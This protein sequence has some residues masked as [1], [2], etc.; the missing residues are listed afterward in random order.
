MQISP[1]FKFAILKIMRLSVQQL[2]LICV[3]ISASY[4]YETNAQEILNQEVSIF[5]KDKSIVSVLKELS[6]QTDVKFVYSS[7]LIGSNK[8]VSID[9]KKQKLSAILNN[10]LQPLLIDFQVNGNNIIL[11]RKSV[12]N[13]EKSPNVDEVE[14]EKTEIS[15][16]VTEPLP[17]TSKA[18]Q[19][20]LLGSL[21]GRITDS[22][23]GEA[24]PGASILLKGTN[25]GS[26]TNL[27][28][29]FSMSL[30]P[31]GKQTFIVSYLGYQ[32]QELPF[33]ITDGNNILNIKLKEASGELNEVVVRGSLEGQQKA[34]NQQ[35]TADNI[36]NVI[37]A[38]L[39]G[40]FPDL[41]VAEALQR[42]PGINIERDRGEGG[43]VQMRGAPPS[44][45]TIN[46]NGEQIP[47]TQTDGQRNEELSIIP[48]D[49][50]SSI[51]VT[52]AITSDMDG[53]NIGGT[54]DFRTPS[55]KN[56][57]WKGKAE[58]GG[59]YNN[60]VQ[61]A[62][63]IGKF[64]INRRFAPTDNLPDGRFGINIGG[65]YFG[66][67]LGRDRVS[68]NYNSSY[69]KVN[70]KDY[71]L[72]TYYRLR[73]LENFRSRT[74]IS[75]AMD[76]KFSPKSDIYLNYMYSR[77][78]DFDEEARTQFDFNAA[79]WT[80]DET[81]GLATGNGATTTRRFIN[82]RFNDVNNHSL[83]FGGNH[84]LGKMAVDYLLFGSKSHN[85]AFVGRVYDLRSTAQATT[86]QGWGTDFANVIG[87]TDIHDPFAIRSIRS[88]TDQDQNIDA[89]NLSAKINFTVPY[90]I[91]D[92]SSSIKFGGKYRTLNNR[93][94]IDNKRYNFANDGTVNV[95]SLFARYTSER[96]DNT[97]LQKRVRFGPTLN[98]KGFDSFIASNPSLWKFDQNVSTN[99]SI[100][101][102]YDADE[103][104]F[105]AY[106]MNKIN[107]NKLMLLTGLRYERTTV[108]YISRAFEF[109]GSGN[110]KQQSIR[111]VSG[112][113]NFDFILPNLHLKYSIDEM[114]NIR[115]ALTYS[116]A[117]SNFA[118][119]A[120]V[121][122]V[123]V[124]NL[125]ISLGNPSLKPASSTNLD[126]LFERYFKNVGILS[127]G[128]FMKTIKDFNFDRSF[129]EEREV[130]VRN[131]ATG[132]FEPIRETF[133]INQAQNGETASIFGFELNL[134]SNLTFLPGILKGIGVYANYTYTNSKASTF[135]RKEVRLP[136]Q[137]MH[138]GNF[139]LSFDYK[140]LSV[141]GSFN[142]NGGLIRTL[143]PSGVGEN[144]GDFDTWR[145]DRYQLDLS[146]S[147]AITKK[148]RAYA[149]F[150][151]VTNR[152]DVEYFGNRSR[153]S[154]LEYFDWWNR[155]GISYNF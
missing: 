29:E 121:Q 129:T 42:I 54:V 80:V 72:P 35:R 110:V 25:K 33:E 78:Y 122:S 1:N 76:Y 75:A 142:Y 66:S 105:A 32:K 38:D 14:A 118:D 28:G 22:K 136:G 53:D 7:K 88:Y 24:L 20:L 107:F 55:G 27:R 70:N 100:P 126:F 152:P 137:A 11:N 31:V 45:T 68:Y 34:L 21:N 74:G 140:K 64:S 86:F 89:Q 95:N 63:F 119:L 41:N 106:V 98:Y 81:T 91:G 120:P 116:Y 39:I 131:D 19:T 50:L 57:N 18:K 3:F 143:G 133:T 115:G 117:R 30:V 36:K 56:L 23:T 73:D 71:V 109:D 134:Q 94:E 46:I 99:E 139:A 37:S 40:R 84:T 82:P 58:L 6:T 148:I 79:R 49:Q 44:F 112:G 154:N 111:D 85:D 104:V 141:K 61:R 12:S 87:T 92:N 9:M 146:A 10:L 43:E 130:F 96:E 4:A 52:K 102:F 128:V 51:E 59:G 26:I 145:D 124:N 62:S 153:V 135:D 147:Y 83:T 5:V 93:R 114:T 155:F 132:A 67:N 48:V 101:A 77:R 127:G 2:L 65:S 60:I 103:N 151:N 69:T 150:I 108:N 13:V 47:G 16:S 97:F 144:T 123:N 15:N 8:K 138:T 125:T 90:M 17:N 149:E 113:T